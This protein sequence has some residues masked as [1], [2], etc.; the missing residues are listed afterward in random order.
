MGGSSSD[1]GNAIT[2]D[3]QDHIIVTGQTD[4]ADFPTS[5][6]VDTTESRHDNVSLVVLNQDG[7]LLLSMIFGGADDDVGIGVAWHSD[8]SF[9]VVGYTESADFPWWR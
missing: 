2:I 3:S 6:P 1:Y 9:I 4:S 7:S 5:F 8:D